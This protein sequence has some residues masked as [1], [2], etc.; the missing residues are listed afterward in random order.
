MRVRCMSPSRGALLFLALAVAVRTWKHA[1]AEIDTS[2]ACDVHPAFKE[3]IQRD[4][5]WLDEAG[6][7]T[8]AMIRNISLVCDKAVSHRCNGK[9]VRL[10]IK[11]GQVYLNS[12]QPD[13]RFGPYEVPGFLLE[14][15]ELSRLYSLPDV[16]FAYNGEDDAIALFDF[17]DRE[18]LQTRFH[19]GPFPLLAWA[20]SPVSSAILV[21][22]SGA[23]RCLHDSF[24]QLLMQLEEIRR[25]PWANRT[26]IAF[27]RWN[28]FCAPYQLLGGGRLPSGE[29][30]KCPRAW[31]PRVA[32]HFPEL[33][34]LG[35]LADP[36]LESGATRKRSVPLMHQNQF[37]YLV[38][39]DGFATSRK[40]E[41]Y[42]LLGSLV[43]KAG[44]SRRG[45]FYDALV[46]DTHYLP[47]MND[48]GSDVADR[49][50][51]A[52]AHDSQAAAIAA[53]G[54]ALAVRH[55]NRRARLCYLRLLL[56]QLAARMRYS[57]SCGQ[58]RLCVPLGRLVEVMAEHP[59]SRES[60]RWSEVLLSHPTPPDQRTAWPDSRLLALLSDPLL[61]PRDN[62]DSLPPPDSDP[63][64]NNMYAV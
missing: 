12:L 47:C 5:S 6:G 64:A 44:S 24:D 14:L 30:F 57:P 28:K 54:Q 31:L 13:W 55:L 19:G 49:V 51:W 60:C 43:L 48:S 26:K 34:D 58:R 29:A 39:T 22:D 38:S 50:R 25:L 1:G 11:D 59:R 15:Y 17:K 8:D 45:Y 3:R 27:G 46:P 23:F 41:V 52:R 35:S 21:P 62:P 36:R 61:W 53:A 7:I 32:A 2:C 42:L 56:Q 9:V 4:L 20:K 40:L 10:M 16:E 33:M 18:K 37:A 63:F